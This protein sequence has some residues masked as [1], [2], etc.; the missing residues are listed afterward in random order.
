VS[1]SEEHPMQRALIFLSLVFLLSCGSDSDP[2]SPGAG[3][4]PVPSVL[5]PNPDGMLLDGAEDDAATAATENL[6]PSPVAA[7]QMMGRL[8]T[9]RLAAVIAPGAT[10]GE[11]NAALAAH[12]AAIVSM[13][14]GLPAV[15]LVVPA[16]DDLAA[17]RALAAELVATGAFAHARP[18][19]GAVRV[20]ESAP[21]SDKDLPDAE[22][23]ARTPHALPMRLPAA[24]NLREAA[25]DE[26]AL[27][28]PNWYADVPGY[29]EI[30]QLSF[31]SFG[32]PIPEANPDYAVG[33]LGLYML[34]VAAANWEYDPDF[35]PHT[36]TDAAAAEALAVIGVHTYGLDASDVL[37]MTSLALLLDLPADPARVVLLD[38]ET[39]D[40][41]GFEYYRFVDRAWLALQWRQAVHNTSPIGA[42][43]V[44]VVAAGATRHVN[45]PWDDAILN[46]TAGVASL[47]DLPAVAFV[48]ATED[49][50]AGFSAAYQAAIAQNPSIAQPLTNVLI[51][52]S[53]DASGNE[54][55]FSAPGSNVR[56]VGEGVVGPCLVGE[57]CD[58][59]SMTLNT[60]AAAAAQV[61]G[62]ACYL[63][64]L[65]GTLTPDDLLLRLQHAYSAS[66]T[67]GILDASIAALSVERAG[68]QAELRELLLDVWG[69]DDDADGRFT[70]HDIEK[71][72]E[73]FD[74]FAGAIAPDYSVYD[75]NGDGWT[76]G[77]GG[78]RMDL[79]AN[80]LPGFTRVEQLIGGETV[81]FEEASVTDEEV[82]CYFAYS[83]LYAGSAE[84]RDELLGGRCGGEAVLPG[85]DMIAD[86]G[87][88]IEGYEVGDYESADDWRQVFITDF[89][90]YAAVLDSTISIGALN[91]RASVHTTAGLHRE[92]GGTVTLAVNLEA[93]ARVSWPAET[94]DA[95]A[96]GETECHVG[97]EIV[98]EH[99]VTVSGG[100][101]LD[102]PQE[103]A[104][105]S[106]YAHVGPDSS[107]AGW[108]FPGGGTWRLDLDEVV[109]GIIDLA[110][111]TA[112]I[113]D[114]THRLWVNLSG[115][116]SVEEDTD[117]F[118]TGTRQANAKI[119]DLLIILTPA[120]AANASVRLITR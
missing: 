82:L 76:A 75:L 43:Y 2:A 57:Q 31:G 19:I 74:A 85:A 29:T 116:A 53:S 99:T 80:D 35:S 44:H 56:V 64:H 97:L 9:T 69:P 54:S 95:R 14:A 96:Y 5:P 12:G 66:D 118:P 33:G 86:I 92:P 24:W 73:A 27:V 120:E 103:E 17:A 105:G 111:E 6:V 60:T 13:T 30:P 8:L 39:F 32:Q 79:D 78:A 94:D 15:T 28:H 61:A 67:P 20:V 36:G 89:G 34:G 90:D 37:A 11:V 101:S 52:G 21:A 113:P 104:R 114:G 3:P 100:L 58:G 91:A 38:T 71:F 10:V 22:V 48:D 50:Y 119:E 77:S 1:I 81:S 87:L 46:S 18:A 55:S 109:G 16:V 68:G 49:E 70:E 42:A 45:D 115:F 26:V 4:E 40:D 106:V 23:A 65:D 72:L 93:M 62:L 110:G 98:G 88:D 59:V 108:S 112:T 117:D 41:P 51:V 107:L 25:T 63:W 84:V 7:E 102:G 83:P 47:P